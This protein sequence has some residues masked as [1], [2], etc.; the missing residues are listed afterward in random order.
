VY[1]A[2][3]KNGES[4]AVVSGRNADALICSELFEEL[5]GDVIPLA[6]TKVEC[7]RVKDVYSFVQNNLDS[8]RLR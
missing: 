6:E 8:G 7:Q 3:K 2:P 5:G 1:F 4:E